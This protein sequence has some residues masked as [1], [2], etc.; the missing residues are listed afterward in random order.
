MNT[1]SAPFANMCGDLIDVAAEEA[2]HFSCNAVVLER[3]IVLPEGAPKLVT[4]VARSRLSIVIHC[5]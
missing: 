2:A 5:R 1:V 3:D 4:R